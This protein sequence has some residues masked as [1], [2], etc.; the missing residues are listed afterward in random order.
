M[1]IA[2]QSTKYSLCGANYSSLKI[3]SQI[4]FTYQRYLFFTCCCFNAQRRIYRQTYSLIVHY[5]STSSMTFFQPL[6][7]FCI[8]I[9]LIIANTFIMAIKK[10]PKKV[11]L[12]N[13]LFRV[14]ELFTHQPLLSKWV[15]QNNRFITIRTGRNNVYGYTG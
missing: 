5:A 14:K 2:H 8:Y 13:I 1:T 10:P 4:N 15:D 12:N 6:A 11:V 3:V 9:Q 7:M